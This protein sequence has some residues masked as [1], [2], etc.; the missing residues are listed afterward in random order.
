[1]AANQIQNTIQDPISSSQ[2]Q[3]GTY[4]LTPEQLEALNTISQESEVK[5]SPSINVHNPNPIRIIVEF[6]QAPA[7]VAVIQQKI[8]GK[9]ISLTDAKKDVNDSHKNLE[10]LFKK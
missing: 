2:S 10:T 7:E 6:K 3:T 4:Q 1:M 9:R 5:I 8:L